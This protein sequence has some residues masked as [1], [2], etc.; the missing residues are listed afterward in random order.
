MIS[1]HSFFYE[2]SKRF[3]P[4]K[5]VIYICVIFSLLVALIFSRLL[6]KKGLMSNRFLESFMQKLHVRVCSYIRHHKIVN[7]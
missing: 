2:K 3:S 4:G 5:F 1:C 6:S 7:L